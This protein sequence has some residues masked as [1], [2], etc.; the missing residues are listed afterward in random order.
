M[1]PAGTIKYS[2]PRLKL[3]FLWH[4]H[5]PYYKDLLTGEY[6]L[7][8]V[9]LHG[10]KDY[11]DM[12]EILDTHPN[13]KQTFNMVPS[14]LEQLDDYARG[15]ALDPHLALSQKKAE[16][17]SDDDK[18]QMIN[19]MFQA[20]A[21]T[22]ISPFKRYAFLFRDRQRAV[23]NWTSTEWRDLQA[24]AN[25]VWIDPMYR[26]K[27]RLQELMSKGEGYS[28]S[29]KQEILDAQ[30][31]IIGQ[32]VPALKKRMESGQIEVSVT[33]YF[34][35]ILPLLC[36]TSSALVAMP[37]APMPQKRF[38]HPEDAERQ[39]ENAVNLYNKLFGRNPLGM[40]PS[41]G[42]VS[43]D[44]IP[45]IS[46]YGIKWIAT[47][48]EILAESLG[49]SSRS[50]DASS[51]MTSGRLYCGYEFEKSGNRIAIFFRDHALSDNIGFV[52]S[53]WD[54]EKAADDFIA[55]LQAIHKN[56]IAK[57]VENPIVPIILDGEN[58]WEYYKNDGHDFL[59]ALYSRIDNTPWLEAVT[60]SQF[61]TDS[62]K[63]GQLKKLFPGSWI[64]HNFAVWIGH[65]EDNQAWDMVS[66]ARDELVEFQKSHPEFDKRKLELAWKEIYISEGSDW[67]WWF[68]PDHIG[69][70]NDD[71]DR[72]FRSHLANVYHFTDRE[73]PAELFTPIRS[74]FIDAHYNKP[75]DFIKPAIDG[76]LS[77]FYEWQQAGF[78]DCTKAGSTMH[79]AER[80][81]SGIWFGFDETNLYF[82]IDR[83]VT[84]DRSRFEGFKFLLEFYN[85]L[86]SEL[87]IQPKERV[88]KFNSKDISEIKFAL[89]DFLE[90]SIPIKILSIQG[91]T[92]LL[93]HLS[94]ME[95]NETL[96]VWPPSEALRIDLPGP[97]SIPW[98]V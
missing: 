59:E 22:M 42:S 6:L 53:G 16:E 5:Q 60:F 32:I 48:E 75:I 7:P 47:D 25:L 55:K 65:P 50:D 30:R 3:G 37:S 17:L 1:A 73:P 41:E 44:I 51:L 85:T 23:V 61:L 29:E 68:G 77:H 35:P 19:L 4:Q 84:V 13:L 62:P 66:R 80:L 72:L 9:R 34:H 76:K 14:L 83:S 15:E 46:K 95:N 94:I 93:V 10:V 49:V 86:K 11:L 58:A 69:P 90:F 38:Q 91:E 39:V 12:V 70:N 78:F 79:K 21:D 36:D 20:N 54:A 28:E 71:F 40:W 67:C 96:E 52:Y 33:P 2:G 24:L 43:E 74:N 87:S 89:V 97:G 57:K 8:W 45:I 88:I 63:M 81:I 92:K 27:G 26:T 98:S 31:K 82:R 56:I 18:I 64:S